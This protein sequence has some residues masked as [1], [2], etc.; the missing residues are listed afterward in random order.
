MILTYTSGGDHKTS[1]PE[2]LFIYSKSKGAPKTYLRPSPLWD[3][4][5][6]TFIY[7]NPFPEPEREVV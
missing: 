3:S 5:S 4:T 6:F 2:D 7:I 1:I